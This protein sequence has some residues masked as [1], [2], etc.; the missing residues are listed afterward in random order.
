MNHGGP[1]NRQGGGGLKDELTRRKVKDGYFGGYF[2]EAGC[3]KREFVDEWADTLA[4]IFGDARLTKS[5]L[6]AFFAETKRLQTIFRIRGDKADLLNRLAAL[7]AVAHQRANRTA[8][9]RIPPVFH[10]FIDRN[11]DRVI[12]KEDF[13]AFVQHFEA[14]V[15]YCEGR[16]RKE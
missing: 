14:V 2:G 13:Q 7:K 1:H 11:V 10:E 9:V 8:S 4:L 16:I 6:R 12:T 5:Q 15:A 3:L